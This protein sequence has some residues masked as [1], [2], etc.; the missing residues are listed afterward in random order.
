[1]F[2]KFLSGNFKLLKDA[3]ESGEDISVFGLNIGEKIALLDDSAFLFFVVENEDKIIDICDK[4]NDMGRFCQYISSPLTPMNSEFESSEKVMAILNDIKDG[5]INTLVIT[6]EVLAGKFPK[7][8][9]LVSKVLKKGDAISISQFSQDLIA[10]NYHRVD[11]V[12]S[13]NEFSIRG[14][15]IDV[16]PA[17][18]KP[19]RIFVDFDCV[20]NIKEF[21]PITMLTSNEVESLSLGI[22]SFNFCTKQDI[23]DFYAKNKLKYDETYEDLCAL[24]S[25]DYRLMAIVSD[26]YSSIFDYVPN[27]VI[28]FDGAK[29][30]YDKLESFVKNYNEKISELKYP[31]NVLMLSSKLDM[32][33]CL[34][35]SNQSKIAFHYITNANRLFSPKKVFSIRTLPPM[36]YANYLDGLGLDIINFKNQDYTI[37]LCIGSEENV[38]KFSQILNKINV[39]FNTFGSMSLCIKNNVNLLTKKYPIDIILP[40]EKLIIISTNS[41]IGKRKK[42][43]NTKV[44]FFDGEIPQKDDFV[45]HNVHGVGRCL[46]VQTL[47]LTNSLR[48]YV[49]IEYKNND[50][51][52]L[53]VE[54]M[55]Q[56]SKYLGSDKA[57]SLNKIGGVEFAKTKA[58]VKA[59]VK[60][61]AFDLVNLYRERMNASGY[62]YTKDDEIIENF[63]NSFEFNETTDQLKAV[64]DC[65]KDMEEGKIMDRLVCGDVG[66]GKTEVALRVA[67]KTI[68]SGKQV[69]FLCPTTILSEQHFSTAKSRMSD[70]GVKIE[71]IN[72]LKSA[73]EIA[74]IKKDLKDGKIDLII[75]THKLLAGDIKYKNLGLLILDEEQKFGVSDKDKIKNIKK[76]INVLTLSATPIPRTLNLSLIGVR[77]ISVI[78]SPPVERISS[79]VQVVEY[80]DDI[81]KKA[82][83]FELGRGGQVLI[84]YNRVETIYKFASLVS[85][86]A[87]QASIGVAHGQMTANELEKEIFKLYSGETQILVATTLIENGVDLPNANTLIVINSDMLGLSQLY[88]LKGRIGRSNKNSYAYFTFDNKKLLTE[89]AYKR[90]QAIKE[91]SGMGS[92]FKIAMRDLEIRGAGTLL[93]AEQSGHMEKI[94]YNMYVQL[95]ESSIRE[96]NNQRVVEKSDVRIETNISAFLSHDYVP[97]SMARMK[98]YQDISRIDSSEKYIEFVCNTE[99]IYGDLPQELI[100]LA[101]IGLIKNLCSKINATKVIIKDKCAVVLKDK[102]SITSELLKYS[103]EEYSQYVNFNFSDTP[104]IEILGVEKSEMLDFLISYLQ[105]VE[106]L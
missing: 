35:Y 62:K 49:V 20:E 86:F 60:K 6:P 92:G 10:M 88:Q 101:K 71:V 30:I 66:F 98:M 72:R 7:K 84:I 83:N 87:P 25:N 52:Y 15:I 33:S 22:N 43:D 31:L 57:P 21:N 5:K 18:Y 69:A 48:D 50:K 37:I 11:L 51:L 44:D 38:P 105:F 58:K 16:Y 32:K 103:M 55:D 40:D 4:F 79:D 82:I 70:F 75:G 45:V 34:K 104:T 81:V 59:V 2:E 99:N 90:L 26:N 89:N 85:T 27:G 46:G 14:D 64:Q 28:A 29:A 41:L 80:S 100:N 67:F 95:L 77:D 91:F 1:M 74:R 8:D 12:S 56:L 23:D 24:K 96:I 106:C 54:N 65:K 17:S 3:I 61:I 73:S 42:V 68:M 93:G 36:N 102:S 63:E 13:P 9:K 39:S 53:P 97:S 94:G 78:E 47:K 76:S 19:I